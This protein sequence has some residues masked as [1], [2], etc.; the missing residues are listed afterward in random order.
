METKQILLVGKYLLKL[1]PY[2]FVTLSYVALSM[3]FG[4]LLGF[5]LAW[6]KVGKNTVAKEFARGY[7]TVIRCTPSLVLLFL[8]YFGLPALI[9]AI[10]GINISNANSLIFVVI[11]FSLF[12]GASLS[13]I[14]RTSYE[15]V[16]RGQFEAAICV[17]LTDVQ[18]FRRIVLPQAFYF[19][20]PNLGNT[21]I[22]LLKEGS[23]AFTIGLVDLMGKATLINSETM[24]GY[25][26]QIYFAIAILYWSLSVI[27]EKFFV[28]LE[29][30]YCYSHGRE[31]KL[32]GI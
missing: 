29:C 30:R 2:L 11:T 19:A 18:A 25:V 1:F 26:V 6:A 20:L 23:L 31:G 10:T 12:L 22:Y 32:H 21:L 13:E 17:G 4:A 28:K 16:N 15:S 7:T 24:G 8:V 27:I 5:A 9:E 14:M 3:A